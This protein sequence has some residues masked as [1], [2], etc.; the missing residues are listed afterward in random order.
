MKNSPP[1]SLS[2]GEAYI[3]PAIKNIIETDTQLKQ[4]VI[5]KVI[6]NIKWQEHNFFFLPNMNLKECLQI[7]QLISY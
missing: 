3:C 5:I 2:S 4:K 7:E 6:D 1:M